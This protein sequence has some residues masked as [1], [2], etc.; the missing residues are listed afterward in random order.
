VLAREQLRDLQ[1]ESAHL[2]GL[3]AELIVWT[4][5]SYP[6]QIPRT[7]QS[8]RPLTSR[9]RVR[10][11]F[12]APIIIGALTFEPG[13][14]DRRPYNSALMF[15]ENGT[16]VGLFDKVFLLA[17]GEYIPFA[18]T[19]P[20]IQK[21]IPKAAG[22]FRRGDHATTFPLKIGDNQF[23]LG[24]MICYEDILTDFSRQLGALHPHLLVN[25]TNDA[26][27]GA[28]SEPWEHLALSVYRAVELRTEMVRA[29][30]TGVSAFIDATGKVTAK[31]YAV[32]PKVTPKGVDGIVSEVALIEGGHTF[33][34]RFGNVFAYLC[35]LLTLL[36]WQVWPRWRK[37]RTSAGNSQN[38][39]S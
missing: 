21:I 7:A 23:R 30:N 12:S 36:A 16:R 24:P 1:E 6:Y 38:R 14:S 2:E 34:A 13:K 22:Q 32:D 26:W 20:W 11:G 33:F 17:F 4:E 29:V 35:L 25:L 39:R 27:Y 3:G 28:T 37:T 31:T 5:S 18:D 10:R 19:F 8:D 9:G 15:D